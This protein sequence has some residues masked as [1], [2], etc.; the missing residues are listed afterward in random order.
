MRIEP[1]T[2]RHVTTTVV[3]LS[4]FVSVFNMC[5]VTS[6]R[7]RNRNSHSRR[8][9]D[10]QLLEENAP[11]TVR[12]EHSVTHGGR[13]MTVMCQGH[14]TLDKCEGRCEST[15]SPTVVRHRLLKTDCKCCKE[16]HTQLV[17]VN[18]TR[19][20]LPGHSEVIPGLVHTI[21]V[22]KILGCRCLDCDG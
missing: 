10:C 1:M 15:V 22:R 19:C 7:H 2:A 3:S 5:V 13:V 17:P 6:S 16:T 9:D 20:T 14:V 21:N 11:R 4:V 8:N 12:R 18:L